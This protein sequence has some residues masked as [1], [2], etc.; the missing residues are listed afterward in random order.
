MN[1]QE[2][3]LDENQLLDLI[4]GKQIITSVGESKVTIR[5]SYLKPKVQSPIYHRYQITD[6]LAER[7][8]FTSVADNI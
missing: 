8:S 1:E 2:I 4:N 3:T 6:T 5:Q 7:E